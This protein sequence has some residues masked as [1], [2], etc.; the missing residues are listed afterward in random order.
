MYH[1]L[2]QK[3]PYLC[4]MDTGLGCL[5]ASHSYQLDEEEVIQVTNLYISPR[6]KH[7]MHFSVEETAFLIISVRFC[8]L[9]DRPPCAN[10]PSHAF[11]FLQLRQLW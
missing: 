2:H 5:I 6:K 10:P 4:L 7:V 3:I 8:E 1:Q 11:G 9:G